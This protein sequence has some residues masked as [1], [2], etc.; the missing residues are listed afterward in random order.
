MSPA[1]ADAVESA[2]EAGSKDE[3]FQSSC[4]GH[5]AGSREQSLL[6]RLA[7]SRNL[8]YKIFN[9]FERSGAYCALK[10]G[11]KDIESET[12]CAFASILHRVEALD[13]PLLC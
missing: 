8:Q 10:F 11:G 13:A 2:D 4:L 5:E 7:E 6:D 1:D 12:C 3:A 9:E